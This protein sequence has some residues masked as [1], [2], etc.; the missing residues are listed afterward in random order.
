MN[1]EIIIRNSTVGK[2]QENLSSLNQ[3]IELFFLHR[4]IDDVFMTTNL[5]LDQINR[6][7]DTA[8]NKDPNIHITRSIGSVVEFLD[9]SVQNNQGQL[10]TTVFHKPAAEP[11]IVP[12]LSDHPRRI[13]R[14]VIR[15]ALFRA[16]R[17]CSD[18]QDFDRER[19]NTELT[20]L[21]NGYPPRFVSYHFKRFFEQN[22]AI[23]LM[24]QL[25]ND[26]YM[27]LHH[28]LIHQP[29]RRE[30]VQQQKDMLHDQ[31]QSYS[32]EEIQQ[33]QQAC[34]KKEI[35]VPFTFES[36]P[37]LDFQYELRLLWKKY[38]LYHGSPMT[39]V[40]LTIV[41]RINKSLGQLLIQ[42]KPPKSMLINTGS[43]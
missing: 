43:T 33:Q 8:N 40:T 4:Y 41:T 36:G 42:K 9:V 31:Y 24:E 34:N 5:S 39:D 23:S 28:K 19:L 3:L 25:D 15:G 6:L 10:K 22:N 20:L 11:Y 35:C 38:Y 32:S 13:H 2:C 21:L 18:A 16:V 1:I 26:M 17:L 30:R 37:M 29:T 12:F 27:E 7:L 14:N